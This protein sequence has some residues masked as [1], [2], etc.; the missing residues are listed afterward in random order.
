MLLLSCLLITSDSVT[1]STDL[2]IVQPLLR[3][4]ISRTKTDSSNQV[5]CGIEPVRV[6]QSE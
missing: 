2:C 5:P 4:F 1:S 6:D 3:S